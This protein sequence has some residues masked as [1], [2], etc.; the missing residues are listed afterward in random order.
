[1]F[2]LSHLFR[3]RVAFFSITGE[4]GYFKRSN[5][6]FERM[7]GWSE[8]ELTTLSFY[9][10]THPD[11]ITVA[12]SQMVEVGRTGEDVSFDTRF[13]HKDGRYRWLA[14]DVQG[15]VVAGW[16]YATA[17]DITEQKE[18]YTALE[19]A[20]E[21]LQLAMSL[22]EAGSWSYDIPAD[23]IALDESAAIVMNI[24][25]EDFGGRLADLLL[26]TPIEDHPRVEK[27]RT[28]TTQSEPIEFDFRVSASDG[29][30]RR[31]A[32]RGKVVETDRRGR[33]RRAVGI[34]WNITGQDQIHPIS[35]ARNTA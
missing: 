7:L 13:M 8:P 23:H 20:E 26:L 34:A 27:L 3:S 15:T 29:S 14:W 21:R 9:E 2:D 30:T 5:A 17:W 31:V 4:D 6:A 16:W 1:M 35:V 25:L 19:D 10:L 28:L 24:K 33:P 11:D 18:R 22:S 32:L 12:L